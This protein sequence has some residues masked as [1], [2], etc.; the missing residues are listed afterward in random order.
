MG[1]SKIIGS[2]Q[3]I[4]GKADSVLTTKADL[5]TYSSE[6]IRLGV[7][8]NND[9]LTADS[10][11]ATGLKWASSSGI[12]SPLTSDLV[13]N[14]NVNLKFGTDSD[15]SLDFNGTDLVLNIGLTANRRLLLSKLTVWGEGS[16]NVISSGSITPYANMVSIDTEGASSSDDCD[17]IVLETD[18]TQIFCH[19]A[20]PTRDVTMKDGTNLK[21]AGDFTMTTNEDSMLIVRADTIVKEVSRSDNGW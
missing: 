2:F 8:N 16:C 21:L 4:S 12:S 15:C 10:S 1:S 13:I 7:G 19:S 11:E 20:T 14:D 6:R 17:T 3:N 9:V 18:G 5:A